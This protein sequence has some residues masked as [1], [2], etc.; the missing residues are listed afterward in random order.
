MYWLIYH[1]SG[2]SSYHSFRQALALSNSK[3]KQTKAFF[4]NL[5][6]FPMYGKTD[7]K[8]MTWNHV[9]SLQ[10]QFKFP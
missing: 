7:D 9:Q 1:A 10:F 3:G 4:K 8:Y 6:E 5:Q 2:T